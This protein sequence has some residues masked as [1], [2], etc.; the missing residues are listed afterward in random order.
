[1]THKKD[2]P[3]LPETFPTSK[4]QVAALEERIVLLTQDCNTLANK[5]DKRDKQDRDERDREMTELEE[6]RSS[7]SDTVKDLEHER[8]QR[9]RIAEQLSELHTAHDKLTRRDEKMTE[10]NIYLNELLEK[11]KRKYKRYKSRTEGIIKGVEV[12]AKA[13]RNPY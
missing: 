6:L 1:M 3:D 10:E 12:L 2:Y 9:G 8:S 13:Q 5:L 11:K 4:A 7:H